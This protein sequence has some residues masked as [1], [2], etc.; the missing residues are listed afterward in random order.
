[1]PGD[2]LRVLQGWA[3]GYEQFWPQPAKW[4]ELTDDE[5][6][7]PPRDAPLFGG[8]VHSYQ[9][10]SFVVWLVCDGNVHSQR[11][12]G[13]ARV[14]KTVCSRETAKALLE[15]RYGF[16]RAM[17]PIL[18]LPFAFSEYVTLFVAS[19]LSYGWLA[20]RTV[21][22]FTFTTLPALYVSTNLLRH[23]DTEL[24]KLSLVTSVAVAAATPWL[25]LD[26][27]VRCVS[28]AAH[29]V[30]ELL[31]F[32]TAEARDAGE[33]SEGVAAWAERAAV[34]VAGHVGKPPSGTS[35]R[36]G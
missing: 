15:S 24:S 16:T 9:P 36:S 22:A 6:P 14:P 35:R 25:L 23:V 12:S 19:I 3:R 18:D 29:A 33:A 20:A 13:F 28:E 1:M 11:R 2:R 17:A 27:F 4:W 30:G 10:L 21:I 32:R 8:G 34:T 7:K 26:E 5:P 31:V